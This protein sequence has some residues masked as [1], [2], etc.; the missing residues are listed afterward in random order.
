MIQFEEKIYKSYCDI[1][2][3]FEPSI[4]NK[5][6]LA[7]IF[8]S[9]SVGEGAKYNYMNT[10]SNIDC[11]K[12]FILDDQCG[13][14]CYYL[15]KN[16]SF[17]VEKSVISLIEVYSNNCRIVRNNI[18]C[19]GSSKGGYA[20]LY[21]GLKYSM[22]Y[23]IAGAPQVLLGNYL[24]EE[25]PYTKYIAKYIAG[26]IDEES[27]QYLNNILINEIY[28]CKKFPRI[29]IHV[30]TGDFHYTRHLKPLTKILDNFNVKYYV[31]LANYSEHDK[32]AEY[33]KS[34]A[35]LILPVI[36]R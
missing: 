16:R 31:D 9:L 17:D 23:V 34:F 22:G 6:Y 27:K 36:V 5:P 35:K 20:A 8:S 2:Y 33:F 1:K 15:G 30:G 14:G 24:I 3:V 18:I 7:V 25:Q 10:L 32:V 4:G 19:M 13:D 29:F 11:N 26:D 21:Y 12:L 28:S